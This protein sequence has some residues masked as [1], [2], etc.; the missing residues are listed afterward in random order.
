MANHKQAIKRHKQSITRRDRNRHY[1]TTM[2]SAVKRLRAAIN[3]SAPEDQIQLLYKDAQS[4]IHR[5]AQKGVIKE[6]AANRKVGRLALAITR[7]PVVAPKPR[8]KKRRK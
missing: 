4:T 5:I 8:S 7:G 6:N 2:K 1:K 3:E